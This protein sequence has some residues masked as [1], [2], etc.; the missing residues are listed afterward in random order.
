MIGV[1]AE[2]ENTDPAQRYTSSVND[3]FLLP[4]GAAVKNLF[5]DASRR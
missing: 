5:T 3:T 2:L 1:L 4:I